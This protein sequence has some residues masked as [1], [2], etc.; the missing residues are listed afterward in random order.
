ME[1][2]EFEPEHP[3]TEYQHAT[4]I[5]LAMPASSES[6]TKMIHF[7]LSKCPVWNTV[8]GQEHQMERQGLRKEAMCRESEMRVSS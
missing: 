1:G 3:L 2:L 8:Y 6:S 5:W 7:L 4:F